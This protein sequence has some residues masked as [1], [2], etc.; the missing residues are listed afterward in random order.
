MFDIIVFNSA[1]VVYRFPLFTLR[2]MI[3][4]FQ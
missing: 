4:L 1:G 2:Y 3:L